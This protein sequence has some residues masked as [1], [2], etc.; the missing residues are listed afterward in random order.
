VGVEGGVDAPEAL[1]AV[2]V[3]EREA[4]GERE[5]LRGGGHRGGTGSQAVILANAARQTQPRP[6]S[7]AENVP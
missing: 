7:T 2:E 3:V 6:E 5:G 1:G 4:E